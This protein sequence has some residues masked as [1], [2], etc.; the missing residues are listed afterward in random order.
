MWGI[1]LEWY[2]L[3][4]RQRVPSER[5]VRT[6]DDGRGDFIPVDAKVQGEVFVV[7]G[8]NVNVVADISSTYSS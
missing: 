8:V 2:A 1:W 7:W 5:G 4:T 3:P 6:A